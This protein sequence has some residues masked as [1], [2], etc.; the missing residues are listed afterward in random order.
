MVPSP[1]NW[2][3]SGGVSCKCQ[4]NGGLHSHMAKSK[5]RL[6]SPEATRTNFFILGTPKWL[7]ELALS[8][9]I[10]ITLTIVSLWQSAPPWGYILYTI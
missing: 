1:A 8:T 4:R 7:L 6:I 2:P 10:A 3:Q 9:Y 5:P